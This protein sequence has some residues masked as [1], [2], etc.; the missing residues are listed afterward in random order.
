M[1][2][3]L[4]DGLRELI[5]G[6]PITCSGADGLATLEMVIAAHASSRNGGAPIALPLNEEYRTIDVP[7]T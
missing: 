7:V 3:I 2:D 4:T 6:G 1:V 5:S